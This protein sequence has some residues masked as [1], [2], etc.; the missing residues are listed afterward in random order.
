[1]TQVII[2]RGL[3]GYRSQ[4][5]AHDWFFYWKDKKG[6]DEELS[7]LGAKTSLCSEERRLLPILI[8]KVSEYISEPEG[9]AYD[10]IGYDCGPGWQLYDITY[11]S[12]IRLHLNETLL[13]IDDDIEAVEF[14]L[15]VS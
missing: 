3:V 6:Q 13:V 14:K 11:E 1:M 9:Y 7:A 4:K 10:S 12:I 5:F 8:N 2:K 15:M